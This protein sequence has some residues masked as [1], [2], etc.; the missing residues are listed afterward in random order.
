MSAHEENCVFCKIIAG[1]IPSTKVYE[2]ETCVAFFDIS[3]VTKG[4]TLLIPKT[5]EENIFELQEETAAS[6]MKNAPKIARALKEQF[7]SV[8]M[9][10]VNN[11]GEAASQTV[12]HYHLHFIPR[13]GD[14]EIYSNWDQNQGDKL[15]TDEMQKIAAQLQTRLA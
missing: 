9:N 15:S 14:D 2:D 8:G 3:Q 7:G 10:L 6:L 1:D 13:Y 5:H 12:F 11:N 4:H